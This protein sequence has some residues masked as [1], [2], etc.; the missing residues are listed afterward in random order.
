M[1]GNPSESNLVDCP[2]PSWCRGAVQREL[3]KCALKVAD[4]AIAA[5]ETCAVNR[6]RAAE[7]ALVAAIDARV[8]AELPSLAKK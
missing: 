6:Q 1:A 4:A 3:A 5:G 8:D 7:D 2:R